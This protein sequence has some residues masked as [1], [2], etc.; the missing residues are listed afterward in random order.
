M[1]VLYEQ[2]LYDPNMVLCFQG[3]LQDCRSNLVEQ[4]GKTFEIEKLV[5]RLN[6]VQCLHLHSIYKLESLRL[7]HLSVQWFNTVCTCIYKCV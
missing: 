6:F 3:E 2:C 7:V 5:G 4:L 1:H